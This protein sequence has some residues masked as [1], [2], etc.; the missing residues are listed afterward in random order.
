MEGEEGGKAKKQNQTK[1]KTK[2]T[3]GFKIDK[4]VF[5]IF[6]T[7]FLLH[8]IETGPRICAGVLFYLF[9]FKELVPLFICIIMMLLM[10]GIHIHVFL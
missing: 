10:L 3:R 7:C 4:T 9:L 6:F 8:W 1:P 2:H 5:L